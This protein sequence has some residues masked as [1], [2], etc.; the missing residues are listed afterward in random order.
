MTG[1]V[2]GEVALLDGLFGGDECEL[3]GAVG[4]RD[5]AGGEMGGGVE[6]AHLSHLDEAD[7]GGAVGFGDGFDGGDA[8]GAGEERRAE[9]VDGRADGGDA[10]EAGDSYA[11]RRLRHDFL[12]WF[13]PG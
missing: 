6:V 4:G 3:G 7:A 2:L 12:L 11:L 1:V 13:D 8:G 10:A 5:G 9:V